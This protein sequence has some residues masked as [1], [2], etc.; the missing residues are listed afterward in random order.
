MK[1]WASLSAC[2]VVCGVHR[3]EREPEWECQKRIRSSWVNLNQ[4]NIPYAPASSTGVWDPQ[5]DMSSRIWPDA[6]TLDAPFISLCNVL[7][8]LCMLR[9]IREHQEGLL[10]DTWMNEEEDN[11]HSGY[12]EVFAFLKCQLVVRNWSVIR[13]EVK[14]GCGNLI[15]TY[16][17]EI[18]T[19]YSVMQ[20]ISGYIRDFAHACARWVLDS[21]IISN[22][23]PFRN[24]LQFGR[25]KALSFGWPK[26][27][28]EYYQCF[29]ADKPKI[30][31]D[32]SREAH[33]AIY[34]T[35]YTGM[36]QYPL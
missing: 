3:E 31:I 4:R 21:I 30:Q 16:R 36:Y 20:L 12:V 6:Y 11:H 8:S 23:E 29:G 26:G 18:N 15:Q 33:F 34:N 35:L 10:R 24:V 32:I 28:T 25:P 2:G 7:I 17:T 13:A 27:V 1:T 5:V 9:D 14:T 19:I 22:S